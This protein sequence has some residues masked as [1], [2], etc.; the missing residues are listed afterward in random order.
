MIGAGDPSRYGRARF[1]GPARRLNLSDEPAGLDVFARRHLMA[2]SRGYPLA[3][4]PPPEAAK[5]RPA[6]N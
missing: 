4:P 3:P 6:H 1:A 2:G 5:R